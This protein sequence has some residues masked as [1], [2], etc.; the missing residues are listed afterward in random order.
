M[1]ACLAGGVWLQELMH[2]SSFSSRSFQIFFP[3]Q[4]ARRSQHEIQYLDLDLHPEAKQSPK[5]TKAGTQKN[6]AG[7]AASSVVY[8]TV[9]F[10]KT[11]AFNKMRINV[12][13]SYR[14]NQ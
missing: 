5:P 9:D 2:A 4:S 11:E 3:L 14:K 13:D 10:V 1:S 6:C 7:A 12:E 8:K